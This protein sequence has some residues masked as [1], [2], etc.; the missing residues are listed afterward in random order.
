[1]AGENDFGAYDA[2]IERNFEAMVEE[3]RHFCSQPTLAGQGIG[4]EEGVAL[5]REA[6]EPLGASVKVVPIGGGPPVVLA[7]LGSGERTLLLYNHYDVQPPEPLELWESPPYAGDVREGR[8]YARGVADDRG[9]LLSRVLA[10]RAYKATVGDLPL[11]IR[12][13]IEGEEEVGSPHLGPI[14]TAHAE[15]LRADWCAWEGSGLDVHDNPQVICGLKG[16]LY[17]ELH[18]TGPSYDAHSGLGGILPN[19]AWRLVMA[20]STLRDARGNFVMDG[21]E[22]LVDRP[23]EA[24]LEAIKRIPYDEQARLDLY[25]IKGWQRGISGQETLVVEQFEPTA[26]IAGFVSGYGGEGSKTIVPSKAMVKMDFRLVPRQT[27]DKML[28]LLRAHL[29]ARGYDDIEIVKLGELQ[30]A[31]TPIDSPLVQVSEQVWRDLGREGVVVVPMTGGSGPASIITDELRI[32]LV[33]TGGVGFS[34]SRVH[35]PNESIRLDD[36]KQGIRYWGR[37][38]ARLAAMDDRR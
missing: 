21:L 3:L 5:V 8:F 6:L 14:A 34:G 20:L 33:M 12:W 16:M 28:A 11:R 15:E 31:K 17:V 7:E 36:F 1:M 38:F 19:P 26:N 35:S 27:P 18:A 25:G 37:F 24:E 4:L 9:D 30:P 10:I 23:S 13:L 32:P 29:D 22:E 2:Y